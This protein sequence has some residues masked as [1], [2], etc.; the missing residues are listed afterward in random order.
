MR[1]GSEILPNTITIKQQKS[2]SELHKQFL[3]IIFVF[4]CTDSLLPTSDSHKRL[5]KGKGRHGMGVVV[6][7]EHT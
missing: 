2:N 7:A 6:Y 4:P 3:H 1:K 5:L